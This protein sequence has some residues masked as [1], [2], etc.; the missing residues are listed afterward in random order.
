MESFVV[1]GA[2]LPLTPHFS[3]GLVY[4]AFMYRMPFLVV[5]VWACV[6]LGIGAVMFL[7]FVWRALRRVPVLTITD[8]T[9]TA[10]LTTRARTVSKSDVLRVVTILGSV[11]L[12]IRGARPLRLPVWFYEHPAL[13]MNQLETF[14]AND[15]PAAEAKVGS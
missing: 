6:T 7:P 10:L 12:R 8:T 3:D 4:T 11:D 5:L 1:A 13:V 2:V 14:V 15:G 9:I